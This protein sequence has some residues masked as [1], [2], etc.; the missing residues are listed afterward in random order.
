MQ[1]SSLTLHP[2][3]Y[4]SCSENKRYHL[5]KQAGLEKKNEGKIIL[6]PQRNFEQA[7]EDL[8]GFSRLWVIFW[9]HQNSHWKPKVHPPHGPP[10]RGLF[11]TRSPH[12]PNP[13]GLSCV[14]LIEIRGL[15]IRVGAHDILD[16]TPILDLKPYIEYAESWSHTRQGW[17]EDYAQLPSY[18]CVWSHLAKRQNDYLVQMAG[19]NV[20]KEIDFRLAL[21]PYPSAH[22]R[23]QYLGE[24]LYQLAYQTWRILY[25]INEKTI[26]VIEIKSGYNEETISG[27]KMS[28]WN[29]VPTHQKFIT[30]FKNHE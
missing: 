18:E 4:F 29:D 16:Q 9:F 30:H 28:S 13:I 10:K 24:N 14:E 12:R 7:L 1:S 2:I 26:H 25:Q 17:L 5:P 8:A 27:K 19:M 21:N 6:N 3:G 23:I 20:Q 15:E 11:A 22:N